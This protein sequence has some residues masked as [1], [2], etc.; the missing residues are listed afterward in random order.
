MAF[1]VSAPPLPSAS[2][3]RKGACASVAALE[4][5]SHSGVGLPFAFGG[6]CMPAH[7]STSARDS[8]TPSICM[9]ALSVSNASTE[10]AASFSTSACSLAACL[11]FA[12]FF[13]SSAAARLAATSF[14]SVSG[15]SS[16]QVLDAPS[17]VASSSRTPIAVSASSRTWSHALSTAPWPS[18][19]ADRIAPAKSVSTRTTCSL[20]RAATGAP[21]CAFSATASHAATMSSIAPFLRA[22]ERTA[23]RNSVSASRG[24]STSDSEPALETGKPSSSEPSATPSTLRICVTYT[25]AFCSR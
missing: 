5:S 20:R 9:S 25:P 15:S 16:F 3:L 24:P 7:A 6:G 19:A 1:S 4:A 2:F 21:V 23:S 10:P 11:A 12:A 17:R 14:R 13:A 8:A 22:M 18:A